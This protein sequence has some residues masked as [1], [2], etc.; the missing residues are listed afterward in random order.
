MA[1]YL[2]VSHQ[3][4]TPPPLPTPCI[5]KNNI[6]CT[7]FINGVIFQ[8]LRNAITVEF[9]GMQHVPRNKMNGKMPKISVKLN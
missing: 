4:P 2:R 8:Q 9:H 1:F 3:P 7:I 5:S 6:H